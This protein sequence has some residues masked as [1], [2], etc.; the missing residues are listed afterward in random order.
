[1]RRFFRSLLLTTCCFFS[2]TLLAYPNKSITIIVPQ[3][4]GGTND[5]VGRLVAQRLGEQM[6]ISIVVEN[7]PGA[8]GNIGTQWVAN[9]PKDGHTL[10]MTISSAQAINPALYKN[11]GF[12]PVND[13]VPI[14]LVGS[15]PNVLVL[16][17]IHN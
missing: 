8:G 4:P 1:M 10:L 9:G 17:L 6:K 3:A 5:I 7:R 2:S 11:P 12:D 16:S 13:F 14:A 15:V